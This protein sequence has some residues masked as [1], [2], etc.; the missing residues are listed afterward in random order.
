M[1]DPGQ[2]L[3]LGTRGLVGGNGRLT[4]GR[5]AR[6]YRLRQP[7]LLDLLGHQPFGLH[8]LEVA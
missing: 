8:G 4:Q 3:A 1:A 5:A 7:L 6:T 2:Q